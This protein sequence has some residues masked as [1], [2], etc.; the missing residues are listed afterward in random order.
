[1][2]NDKKNSDSSN[3]KLGECA[4]G[5]ISWRLRIK[6]FPSAFNKNATQKGQKR[7]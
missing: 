4:N 1:M 7:R 2:A 5:V 6:A 3:S